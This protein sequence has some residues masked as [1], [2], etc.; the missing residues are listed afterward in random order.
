MKNVMPGIG[1]Q[2]IQVNPKD[3]TPQTCAKCG[4][5]H[6]VQV[7]LLGVISGLLPTN[8][9]GKDIPVATPIYVCR[10]CGWEFGVKDCAI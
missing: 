1:Q 5:K 4:N 8:P 6:F 9:I 2:Q 10:A 7:F 3:A